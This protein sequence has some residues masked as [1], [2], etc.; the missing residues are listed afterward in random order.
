MKEYIIVFLFLCGVV[1]C[2]GQAGTEVTNPPGI[3]KAAGAIVAIFSSEEEGAASLRPASLRLKW[4]HEE[5]GECPGDPGCTCEQGLAGGVADDRPIED[6]AFA[7]PGTYGS[8]NLPV[9]VDEDDFCALSDGTESPTQ[10]PDDRG[11]FAT[12]EL[13]GDITLTCT[14]ADGAETTVAMKS[15]SSG[16]WRNTDATETEPAFR[17]QA[18][19]AFVL[20]VEGEETTVDCT[21]FLLE[22]EEIDTS[23]C[24]DE[25][26]ETVEQESDVICEF[27]DS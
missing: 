24:T 18:Y 10:G 20:S 2:G 15:G 8:L 5:G 22:G 6:G 16:I 21:L 3:N 9:T 12:F 7:D 1:H 4:N 13:V 17:P 14:D 19:G 27:N 26:G 25:E 11:R 23:D